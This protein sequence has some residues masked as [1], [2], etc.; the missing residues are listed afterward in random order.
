MST[1]SHRNFGGRMVLLAVS[2]LMLG[3]CM[4][5]RSPGSVSIIAPQLEPVEAESEPVVDWSVGVQRPSADQMRDSDRIMVRVS[6]S[7][8]QP[9]PEAAWLDSMPDMVHAMLIQTLEDSGHFAGVGRAGGLRSRFGLT[10]DI[11]RF[12]V[13]DDGDGRLSVDLA[14]RI[15]L[16]HQPT[17]S[18]M[19]THSFEQAERVDGRSL[20][21]AVDAF[22]QAMSRL[23]LDI[24]QWTVENGE[25]AAAEMQE[26]R[27]GWRERASGSERRGQSR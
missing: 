5:A 18:V 15:N 23:F 20:D 1:V 26:R 25:T 14:V 13:V 8:L 21:D 22:E 11:R 2:V 12:E 9:W 7:R 6:R 17:G 16:V 24:T 19:A 3:G 4:L 10:S 27:E